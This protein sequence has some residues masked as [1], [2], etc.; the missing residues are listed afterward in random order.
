MPAIVLAT[1]FAQF[2]SAQSQSF[3]EA[4]QDAEHYDQCR[5][6]FEYWQNVP[7]STANSSKEHW[8]GFYTHMDPD[9]TRG[10]YCSTYVKYFK[11]RGDS[12]YNSYSRWMKM[13][14][15]YVLDAG[16]AS[17]KKEAI[18]MAHGLFL[19]MS[20]LCPFILD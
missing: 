3:H 1:L 2:Q 14:I 9:I 6:F 15:K 13:R 16:I 19:A 18:A 5:Q 20:D 11:N 17:N 12:N 4:C 10:Q 8:R 7:E